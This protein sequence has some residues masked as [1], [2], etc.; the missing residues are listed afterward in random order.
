MDTSDVKMFG[1]HM[2]QLA[3]VFHREMSPLMQHAYWLALEDLPLAAIA[4]ACGEV[5]KTESFMPVPALLRSYG[6][7]WLQQAGQ[8][9]PAMSA[10]EFLAIR[11]ENV[12]LEEIRCL[13]AE[14]W[15][16]ERERWAKE[17]IPPYTHEG[18]EA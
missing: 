17:P 16:E 18:Q 1:A 13:L 7:A 9:R 8:Q 5:L 11:E 12:S 15:P 3:Q 10:T 14:V 4:Y 2:D 6:K